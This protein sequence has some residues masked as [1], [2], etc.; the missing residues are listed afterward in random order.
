[1]A[2]VMASLR[3][4][5]PRDEV[6]TIQFPSSQ[7]AY[8][9]KETHDDPG[10][11]EDNVPDQHLPE[12]APQAPDMSLVDL[13]EKHSVKEAHEPQQIA[14]SRPEARQESKQED[15]AAAIVDKVDLPNPED[16]NTSRWQ[17]LLSLSERSQSAMLPAACRLLFFL[18]G[19]VIVVLAACGCASAALLA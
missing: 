9:R 1:M 10:I 13:S 19:V 17:S 15:H 7:S 3:R 11:F 5:A 4:V 8:F 14:K 12:Q 6:E 2:E 18:I 16:A